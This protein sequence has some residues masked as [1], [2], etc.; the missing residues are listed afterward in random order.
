MMD[1][2]LSFSTIKWNATIPT[3]KDQYVRVAPIATNTRQ[4]VA[5]TP[6]FCPF[7]PFHT[8][9]NSKY[10]DINFSS[11]EFW[12]RDSSVKIHSSKSGNGLKYFL[13]PESTCAS[14]N[15]DVFNPPFTYF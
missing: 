11:W 1:K 9:S 5:A 3:A 10:L 6:P 14:H 8:P 12:V 13:G 15:F 2:L 4:I 7:A